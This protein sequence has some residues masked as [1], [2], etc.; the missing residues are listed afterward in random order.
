[1][2]LP[3]KCARY[4]VLHFWQQNAYDVE[5]KMRFPSRR[6]KKKPKNG[7]AAKKCPGTRL[8]FYRQP[9][10][11]FS[12]DGAKKKPKDGVTNYKTPRFPARF[13]GEICTRPRKKPKTGS[14]KKRQDFGIFLAA[15]CAPGRNSNLH[16]PPRFFWPFLAVSFKLRRRYFDVGL[17]GRGDYIY[18]VSRKTN[19]KKCP[20][21]KNPN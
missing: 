8:F 13:C 6:P 21:R 2:V 18:R 3:K 19:Q 10:Y 20:E 16:S 12:S 9:E 5:I 14:R 7:F 1:M 17:G 4:P 11:A 15:K